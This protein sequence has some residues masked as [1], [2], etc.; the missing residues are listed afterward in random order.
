M[1]LDLQQLVGYVA[2][3]T[4]QGQ[5][6]PGERA[7]QPVAATPFVFTDPLRSRDGRGFTAP[8]CAART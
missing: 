6:T 7:P 4:P 5:P 8:T 1:N 3:E 2:E